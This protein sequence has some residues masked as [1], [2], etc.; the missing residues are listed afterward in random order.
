[1]AR[2][3][4]CTEMAEHAVGRS[5]LQV[6]GNLNFNWQKLSHKGK[7]TPGHNQLSTTPNSPI[8]NLM[9][10]WRWVVSFMPLLLCIWGNILPYPL[11]R[12]EGGCLSEPV[13]TIQRR[14]KCLVPT[15]NQTQLWSSSP[16]FSSN[17]WDRLCANNGNVPYLCL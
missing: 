12:K 17:L 8:L 6:H 3:S 7:F 11:Y 16:Y 15:R 4:Y 5:M 14:E 1:L 13:W 9:T 10:T 2:K